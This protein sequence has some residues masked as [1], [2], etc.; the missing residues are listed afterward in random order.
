MVGSRLRIFENKVLRKISGS[1][2]R[3]ISRRNKK[4]NENYYNFY[5]LLRKNDI[6]GIQHA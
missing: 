1:R 6:Y 2:E 4:T 5:S 3:E